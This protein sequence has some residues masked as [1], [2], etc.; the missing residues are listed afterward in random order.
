[1]DVDAL[2]D[3]YKIERQE[4]DAKERMEMELYCEYMEEMGVESAARM[5]KSLDEFAKIEEFTELHKMFEDVMEKAY[6]A[7]KENGESHLKLRKEI[8][9]QVTEV[10]EKYSR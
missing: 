4:K 6:E 1:M 9:K 5:M 7:K 2:L 3:K 8:D 10:N